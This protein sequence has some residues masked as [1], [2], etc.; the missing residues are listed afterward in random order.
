LPLATWFLAIYLLT[1]AKTGL[2]ALSL[3]RQLGVSY[4]AA[5]SLKHKI[6]QIMK[7]RDDSKV[8]SGVIHLAEVYG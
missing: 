8:L 3:H 6:M 2:S 4:N 5:W 1:Q 7:E